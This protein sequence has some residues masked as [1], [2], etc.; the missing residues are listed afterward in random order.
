MTCFVQSLCDRICHIHLMVTIIVKN[1]L[2]GVEN[3]MTGVIIIKSVKRLEILYKSILYY[4]YK[5]FILFWLYIIIIIIISSGT[6]KVKD[7]RYQ[8]FVY[9]HN[10]I[11]LQLFGRQRVSFVLYGCNVFLFLT[12]LHRRRQVCLG[13]N[14]YR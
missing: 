5:Y 1:T 14:S 11:E 8:H 7:Q 12:H 10:G 6:I 3:A 2:Q 4:Y 13:H 9:I